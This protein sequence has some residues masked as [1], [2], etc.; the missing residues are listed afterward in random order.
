MTSSDEGM[1]AQLSDNEKTVLQAIARTRKLRPMGAFS[2][3]E[4]SRK[5]Q[6]RDLNVR[7][8]LEDLQ[9]KRIVRRLDPGKKLWK[10]I[11]PEIEHACEMERFT[12]TLG[13]G[14]IRR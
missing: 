10:V 1:L 9:A 12:R 3:R 4:L 2:E 11:R 7:T 14:V 5:H 8:I 6:V 13:Y